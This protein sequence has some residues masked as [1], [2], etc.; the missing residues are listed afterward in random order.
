MTFDDK[1]VLITGGAAGIGRA[2]ALAFCT[3]GAKVVIA[4]LDTETGAP[5]AAE[6]S[7]LG[8]EA[9]FVNVDVSDAAS[10]DDMIVECIDRFGRLDI[11]I[12]NAGV[13]LEWA[14]IAA[15]DEAQ[16]DKIIAV[17]LKGVWL[18][19]RAEIRQMLRQSGGAIVNTASIAAMAAA[20][21]M[22]AYSA[23]KHGVIGLT[24]TTAVEY[25]KKG[26]RVNAVCPGVIDT[27]MTERAI[28]KG[29]DGIEDYL[30][31]IHP[32]GRL[33]TA[34]EVV[35]AMQWLCSDVAGFTTGAVLPVEGGRLA[36]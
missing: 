22:A 21:N 26:I 29:D 5:T 24:R 17:N 1:V 8:G 10:V 3:R 2:A 11:A 6:A 34:D 23:S 14:P 12:N 4:D 32:M 15:G 30:P 16:F 20:P 35:A 27:A 13:E 28:S 25:A 31:G 36:R 33:G 19:L 9:C 7:V 18:C